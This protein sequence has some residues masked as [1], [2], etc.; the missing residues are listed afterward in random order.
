MQRTAIQ[1]EALLILMILASMIAAGGIIGVIAYHS[2][3][4]F[5]VYLGSGVFA[6]V[7]NAA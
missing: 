7:S 5:Y 6:S 4:S 2:Y 1:G 3:I